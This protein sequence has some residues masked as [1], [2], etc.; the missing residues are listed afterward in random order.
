[1]KSLFLVS[2]SVIL[3]IVLFQNVF[4][5]SNNTTATIAE[6]FKDCFLE[7]KASSSSFAFGSGLH[8]LIM[9]LCYETY[10]GEGKF[11]QQLSEEEILNINKKIEELTKA[12]DLKKIL[13]AF[14]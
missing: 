7:L 10:K 4:A 9:M 3:S 2:S 8:N 11:N 1:M 13:N 12:S 6:D 5:Q 14:P